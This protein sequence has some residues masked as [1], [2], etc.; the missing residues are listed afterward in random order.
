MLQIRYLNVAERMG[1]KQEYETYLRKS[2]LST[3]EVVIMNA[4]L[5]A[6][7]LSAIIWAY[8][9]TNYENP[10]SYH[11]EKPKEMGVEL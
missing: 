4:A 11:Y 5:I 8:R 2:K 1:E 6:S 3:R 10:P 9:K 7:R